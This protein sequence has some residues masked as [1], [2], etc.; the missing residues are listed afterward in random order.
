FPD[1]KISGSIEKIASVPVGGSYEV[2][3][4]LNG[5][6]VPVIPGMSAMV[7]DTTYEKKDALTL[8]SSCIFSDDGD[9]DKQVVYK[10]AANGK[11]D[12]VTVKIG[13]KAGGKVEIL[14]GLSDGDE[15]LLTK[16]GPA[17]PTGGEG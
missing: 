6:D 3:V 11:P 12:K 2:K 4:K 10:P 1:A 5:M 17:K 9:D 14:S 13:K 8:P 16:P 7:K 15:V